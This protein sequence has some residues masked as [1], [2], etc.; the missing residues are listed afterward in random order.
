MRR[1]PVAY[2]AITRYHNDSYDFYAVVEIPRRWT[3]GFKPS[4]R[5][6]FRHGKCAIDTI[7]TT[8]IAATQ[9][10]L[11]NSLATADLSVYRY[12]TFAHNKGA[13]LAYTSTKNTTTATN[14]VKISTTN[15]GHI[16]QYYLGGRIV[17]LFCCLVHMC[18]V[19]SGGGLFATITL[20]TN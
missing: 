9:G 4:G 16:I 7:S 15:L 6:S 8:K 19:C 10:L 20:F 12:S 13:G 1:C 14:D 2:V 17:G 5:G 3:T 18:G 11:H